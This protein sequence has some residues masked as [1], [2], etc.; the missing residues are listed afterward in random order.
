[1]PFRRLA[2]SLLAGAV[3]AASAHASSSAYYRFPAIR[4]NV[5][6]FTAEGDLWKS[7]ANGGTAQRL[8]THAAAETNAALSHDGRWIAFSASY[9]GEQEAYVMP[10]E[11]GLPKRITFEGGAVVVV[12]W[13][14]QGEILASLQNPRGPDRSRVIVAIKPD[15]LQRRVFPVADANDAVLDDD[16]KYLYFT[17]LGLAITGDNVKRY[18][19]GAHAQLFRFQLDGAQEAQRVF[20]DDA[21]HKRPMWWN[22][23][24]YFISDRDGAD[25]LWSSLPDG[26]EA[27][28]HSTNSAWDVRNAS[29]GDGKVAY[30]L[31]ADIHVLD[32]ASGTD[33]ALSLQLVSDFDQRRKRRI[34]SPLETLSSMTMAGRTERVVLTARGAVSIAG[35][36]TLRRVEL[37]IPEGTRARN[38]VLSHDERWVYAIVDTSGENEIWR[39]AADGS[40]KGERLTIDGDNQRLDLF[41]SPDGKYVAHTDRRGRTWLLDP[42]A[43]TNVIIDDAHKASLGEPA[44]VAWSPDSKNIAFVR[45]GSSEVRSQIGLFNLAGKQLVF[46]TGDRYPSTSPAFSP[47]G[48]WLYFLSA[49]KFQLSNSGPWGDRNMGPIF[50]KRSAMYALALQQG[51]RFPFKPD[52]ELS[53]P[54]PDPAAKAAADADKAKQSTPVKPVAETK[55]VKPSLPEIVYDGLARRIYEV[56]LAPGNYDAL[57]VNDKHLYFSERDGVDGKVTIKTLAITRASPQ[58]EVFVAGARQFA[59]S[60]DGKRVFYNTHAATGPG[61][62][63]IVEAG[64]KQPADISKAKV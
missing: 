55:P 44:N 37:A 50:D 41:P 1:M 34:K 25:R 47:D 17:R 60:A 8:T 33:Q 61:E 39:Y 52:D 24:L 58:P 2:S 22:G 51:N 35:T 27:R 26:T 64:A 31:G 6:V 45:A 20:A 63:F 7:A 19:G 12:G 57:A 30:Q 18:R 32:L 21:N 38:A 5:V 46:V 10:V 62:L 11:G 4:G 40:G 13:T 59:L 28:A 16:G 49:R 23:R 36:G 29:L 42:H 15:T 54:E 48:R 53:T 14:R 56:P 3:I 43:H 9:E